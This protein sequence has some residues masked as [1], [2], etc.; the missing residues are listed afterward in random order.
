MTVWKTRSGIK[1]GTHFFIFL[2]KL[3]Q[4][5]LEK[6]EALLK[7]KDRATIFEEV[8]RFEESERLK[9]QREW[10]VILSGLD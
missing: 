6:Q 9:R 8:M 5:E 2:L 7:Q 3:L 10:M 1:V 4:E